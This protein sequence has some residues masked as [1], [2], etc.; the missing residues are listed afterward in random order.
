MLV[1]ALAWA[2]GGP[3]RALPV[4]QHPD[5]SAVEGLSQSDDYQVWVN[6]I[7]QFVYRSTKSGNH[8][9]ND[10]TSM[11]FLGFDLHG[12]ATVM[13]KPKAKVARYDLRP[14]SAKVLSTLADNTIAFTLDQPRKLVV[15]V[16][17]SYQAV[18]VITANPP[19]TPPA[20]QDVE[21]YYGP[22]VHHVGIH[23]E[24]S[25]GDDVYIADGAIVEGSFSIQHAANVTIRGRGL[26][27]CGE[28]PH[29]EDFKVIR[30]IDTKNVL[31]DG[32]TICNAPGWIISF[33]EG[34]E[35]LTVKNVKMLGNW[36]YN[37]D[38]IQ[39]GT[40]GLLV[41]DCFLECNDDNFSLNGTC[42]Q[43]EIKN[44]ILWN[45]YNGGVFM[46]GWATNGYDWTDWDIH[47]NV[48]FRAGG[49][50][51]Y[52]RKAPFSLKT[53]TE[54]TAQRLKFRNIIV[55]DVVPY[56]HWIDFQMKQKGTIRDISFDNINVL[57]IWDAA[58]E[59]RGYRQESPIE[60]VS[61]HDVRINGQLVA[62]AEAGGLSLINT[63]TVLIQGEVNPNN[64]IAARRAEPAQGP[65]SSPAGNAAPA[66]AAPMAL[67]PNLLASPSFE[68]GLPP[69]S[70]WNP[71]ACKI[72]IVNSPA[73]TGVAAVKVYDR[74]SPQTG[75]VQDITQILRDN[76][77]GDY[78]YTVFVRTE[79]DAFPIEVSLCLV[80]GGQTYYHPAPSVEATPKAWQK[81]QRTQ[82][83][84]WNDL[85]RAY[86][87]VQ[88]A[89]LG[90][91]T[92]F[93]DS[94][95]LARGSVSLAAPAPAAQQS[96]RVADQASTG[97]RY[98][99]ATGR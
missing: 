54:G 7:E 90:T 70:A 25:S 41:D 97:V 77:S 21:H 85:S 68:D 83:L 2:S 87:Y 96:E 78:T 57:K 10:I 60:N 86:F 42:R 58:G 6:G 29:Q 49:C 51:S 34:S 33:W 72:G 82:H 52:D 91:G 99:A 93:I 39:T 46:L 74:T 67:G 55:E 95:S 48:V 47:D 32:V 98:P 11:S 18:L 1:L 8:G 27:A 14:Y 75:A 61:F 59:I 89:G 94:A 22:G 28:W 63:R 64:A 69:W 62:G 76:G 66:G 65:G 19:Q 71:A 45:L 80:D 88:S 44:C 40:V 38:G 20:P 81:T 92:Y 56:G 50:C 84:T 35:N 5:I 24:L 73:Q 15:M 9:T 17:N 36:W 37:S 4:G 53:F 79:A 30:G 13:V 12:P 16:N 43:V 23:Q 26:I 31:I 3:A